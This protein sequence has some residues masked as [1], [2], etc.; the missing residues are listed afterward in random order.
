LRNITSASVIG[1]EQ[2]RAFHYWLTNLSWRTLHNPH[3][4]DL[5]RIPLGILYL[6][7]R[8]GIDSCLWLGMKV[9]RPTEVLML[10][11][12]ANL[13]VAELPAKPFCTPLAVNHSFAL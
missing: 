7:P 9:I 3:L 13:L 2:A 6:Y 1:K 8:R 12:A 5:I 4:P 10:P 11:F